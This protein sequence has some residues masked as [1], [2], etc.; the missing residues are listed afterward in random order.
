MLSPWKHCWGCPWWVTSSQFLTQLELK[1]ML[2]KAKP[3]AR[4]CLD[5]LVPSVSP[6]C[7][8]PTPFSPTFARCWGQVQLRSF[9]V[10]N[11]LGCLSCLKVAERCESCLGEMAVSVLTALYRFVSAGTQGKNIPT[12]TAAVQVSVQRVVG[13]P[14]GCT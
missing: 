10:W 6:H 4:E 1:E 7:A 11:K 2:D 14:L 5:N 9:C 8:A 3:S 12:V 13:T